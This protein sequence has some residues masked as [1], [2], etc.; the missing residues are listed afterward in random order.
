M[1]AGKSLA[2]KQVNFYNDLP[3]IY[4]QLTNGQWPIFLPGDVHAPMIAADEHPIQKL[5]MKVKI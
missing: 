5:L 3:G 2:A 4:F 1:P